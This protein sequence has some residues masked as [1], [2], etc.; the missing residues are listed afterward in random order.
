MN[1]VVEISHKRKKLTA[2]LIEKDEEP[3]F[4]NYSF[5]WENYGGLACSK[6]EAR[7]EIMD[8][9]REAI[10][11]GSYFKGTKELTTETIKK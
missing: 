10:K 7:K 4:W 5:Y 6:R 2:G 3:G 9:A 11:N 8:A 1:T